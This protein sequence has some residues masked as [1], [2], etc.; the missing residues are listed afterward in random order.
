MHSRLLVAPFISSLLQTIRKP[1]MDSRSLRVDSCIIL[2]VCM[3]RMLIADVCRA[4]LHPNLLILETSC[5]CHFVCS[6][7]LLMSP[8]VL[9]LYISP[10]TLWVAPRV[11]R[12]FGVTLLPLFTSTVWL[13]TAPH[14]GLPT[15]GDE[16]PGDFLSLWR[17]R[18]S[19]DLFLKNVPQSSLP[20]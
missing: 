5:S 17:F 7:L 20:F 10:C 3:A 2:T 12:A 13:P 4:E 8:P 16:I 18:E 6:L 11:E 14:L 9:R 1:S 15:P 19:S